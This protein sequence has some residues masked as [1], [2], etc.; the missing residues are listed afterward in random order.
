[1]AARSSDRWPSCE[2]TV[3]DGSSTFQADATPSLCSVSSAS[4]GVACPWPVSKQA[5]KKF[6]E[7]KLEGGLGIARGGL[8]FPVGNKRGGLLR[9]RESAA[10][11]LRVGTK[12]GGL[13]RRS[14]GA[15]A[16]S[17]W[18]TNG[19]LASEE[20][21][22]SAP[23]PCG[24]RKRGACFGLAPLKRARSSSRRPEAQACRPRSGA[25]TAHAAHYHAAHLP[26][27]AAAAS[28]GTVPLSARWPISEARSYRGFNQIGTGG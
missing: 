23:F 2:P 13:L 9:R 16:V 26:P 20:R 21:E 8:S 27:G 22:R 24:K 18:E 28:P 5:P 15:A 6:A 3:R 19:G 10:R 1:V 14:G 25:P 4:C 12:G 11:R 17:L 7:G